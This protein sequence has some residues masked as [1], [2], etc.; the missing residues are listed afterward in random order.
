[1]GKPTA[2]PLI[3]EVLKN[4]NKLGTK[5]ERIKYLQ[6]QDCTAL[7]DILR[8][9]FDTTIELSLPPGEPPFKKFDLTGNK[10]ARELRFE[11]PKFANFIQAVTPK[12]NQFKRET[13]FIDLLEAVHPDDAILFCNAKDKNI[14]LKYVTKAM[15]K[16]A[17]PN[18]IK[19]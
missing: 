16:T 2:K 14:K 1:M 18:L 7:R 3:S 17:F 5:G 9:N 19:K 15:I 13:I 4:A 11:Y 8:I 10:A 12:I 6:E